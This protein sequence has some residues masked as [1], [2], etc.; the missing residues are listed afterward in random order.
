MIFFYLNCLRP[1]ARS[2]SL[3]PLG[4]ET[5]RYPTG[6]RAGETDSV[7]AKLQAMSVKQD[8]LEEENKHLK[9]R[10]HELEARVAAQDRRPPASTSTRGGVAS[11]GSS[12]V[13]KQHDSRRLAR[14]V[15]VPLS[16]LDEALV[17]PNEAPVLPAVTDAVD[18][19]SVY[20]G[21]KVSDLLPEVRH[22]RSAL[23]VRRSCDRTTYSLTAGR[24]RFLAPFAR[25]LVCLG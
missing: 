15:A 13:Q 16:Q 2:F 20:L 9:R 1:T 19:I 14:G 23:Q 12:V 17:E 11:R 7:T 8:R 24:R 6:M 10:T 5:G 22:A 18:K 3:N 21:G 25:S 4:A